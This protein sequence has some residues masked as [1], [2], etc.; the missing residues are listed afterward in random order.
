MLA[1][2]LRYTL[3]VA[4]QYN[5]TVGIFGDTIIITGKTVS[6]FDLRGLSLPNQSRVPYYRPD[7][8]SEF[9]K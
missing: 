7:L 3:I 4:L 2:L 8:S 1:A 6:L 5:R 9:L